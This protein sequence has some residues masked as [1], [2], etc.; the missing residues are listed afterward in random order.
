[1]FLNAESRKRGGYAEE[2]QEGALCGLRSLSVQHQIYQSLKASALD[3]AR[4]R[5]T[6]EMIQI[7]SPETQ[8]YR[9]ASMNHVGPRRPGAPLRPA[10]DLRVVLRVSA[11]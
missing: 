4:P 6:L 7:I 2:N 9:A 3:A 8:L 5:E 10:K 11:S 1:M